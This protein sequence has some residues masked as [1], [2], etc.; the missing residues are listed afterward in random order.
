MLAAPKILLFG[1]RG[2]VGTALQRDLAK[3]G[4]VSS[5]DRTT[6]DLLDTRQLR[7]VI[8]EARPEII[9]NAAAYTA[10]DRAEAEPDVCTAIN[11]TAPGIIAE[12]AKTIDA[13]L[14]HY[15]TDYVFDGLKSDLYSED[16]APCPLNVYGASKLAGDLAV[17]AVNPQSVI[18][19]VGWVYGLEGTNFAKTILKLA[20]ERNDLKIVADQF[21]APTS[22]R[23]IASVTSRIVSRRISARKADCG[24]SNRELSGI[25]NLAPSGIT[26]WHRYAVTLVEEAIRQGYKLRIAKDRISP[27]SSEDFPT[28]ALRPRN[29]SLDTSKIRR[30]LSLQLP[31]WPDDLRLLV[32]G[33]KAMR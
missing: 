1:K 22:T 21:G 11:A 26:S 30:A 31:P 20:N 29:S 18:L 16:D 3:L 28:A 27:I 5:H 23:L 14:I 6:C 4:I 17:L 2:Q 13:Y 33:L 32:S 25:F 9:V 10:V 7:K 12:E 8:Q 24:A 19:R 15:S